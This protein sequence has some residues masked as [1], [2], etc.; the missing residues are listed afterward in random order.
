MRR[1]HPVRTFVC[2]LLAVSTVIGTTPVLARGC[3]CPRTTKPVAHAPQATPAPKACCQT[4]E[5][6]CCSAKSCCADRSKPTVP[7][8]DPGTTGCPCARCDCDHPNRMP[9][10]A[11][12]PTGPQLSDQTTAATVH[13]AP[14]EVLSSIAG[15]GVTFAAQHNSHPPTNLVITLSRLTC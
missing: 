1:V 14:F 11:P 10:A 13:P 9:P 12:S 6:G 5:P 15:N 2:V 7:Q 3:G 4:A 8:G